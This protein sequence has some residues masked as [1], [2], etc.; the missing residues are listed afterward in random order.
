M[1]APAQE[2]TPPPAESTPALPPL[3]PPMEQ[4][5][6]ENQ[7]EALGQPR[8]PLPKPPEQ[9]EAPQPSP[10][11][12]PATAPPPSKGKTAADLAIEREGGEIVPSF[13]EVKPVA[14]AP[15]PAAAPT[16]LDVSAGVLSTGASPPG[17]AVGAPPGQ[18]EFMV[19]VSGHVNAELNVL[20]ACYQLTKRFVTLQV[21]Q[22][23]ADTADVG[24]PM[25][26]PGQRS[27][28]ELA[29]P[30]IALEVYRQVRLN[31]REDEQREMDEMMRVL[32]KL[33]GKV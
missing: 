3:V 6:P 28:I 9:V 22:S 15:P 17:A 11:P 25:M 23:P 13:N 8:L 12:L 10:A 27:P 7:R 16:T 20:H 5:P 31:M 1:E 2:P 30:Q 18:D 21:Q 19:R 32:R 14:G 33:L 24:N 29:E 26:G 4:R